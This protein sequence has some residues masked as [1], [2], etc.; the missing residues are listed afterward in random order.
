MTHRWLKTNKNKKR[1]I[2]LL[3]M[4]KRR[5]TLLIKQKKNRST[6]FVLD[7][8]HSQIR[9]QRHAWRRQRRNIRRLFGIINVNNVFVDIFCF[10][11][12]NVRFLRF[13]HFI[14]GI[15]FEILYWRAKKKKRPLQNNTRVAIDDVVY[16]HHQRKIRPGTNKTNRTGEQHE[17][18]SM[19]D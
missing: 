5:F 16:H 11:N 19:T 4:K 2:H 7:F 6:Y 8:Y 15:N 3:E 18:D 17:N 13:S 1:Q 12:G 14:G 10:G 9:F